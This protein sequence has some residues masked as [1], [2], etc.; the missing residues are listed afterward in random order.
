MTL[1]KKFAGGLI[2]AGMLAAAS[3][4]SANV[5][6]FDDF[7]ADTPVL[8]WAGDSVFLS[9]PQP[10]NVQGLPSVDLVSES[11]G[12]PNLVFQG[13]SVD[14]DGSTGSGFSPAGQIQSIASL[15]LGDYTVTFEMAGNLRSAPV[16]TTQIS[17][18]SSV[19]DLSPPSDQVFTLMTLHFH[20]V[21]GQLSFTDLGPSDQQG[22]L[23][24]NVTVTTG[25]PEA[26]TWA[27]LT[28]GF[29]S[30]GFAAFRRVRKTSTAIA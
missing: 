19:L 22:D 1:V 16:Q 26:S 7:D 6:L 28:A 13:N 24:D 21:S 20:N 30:L 17:I 3:G 15:A 8:N 10:G 27:M 25:V 23:I 2:A 9:I 14:L 29:A 5:V 12:F 18:G 11:D 4:A